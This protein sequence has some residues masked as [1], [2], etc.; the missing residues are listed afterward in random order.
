MKTIPKS[1]LDLL[2]Q[3]WQ[4]T[5]SGTGSAFESVFEEE[6]RRRNP[7]FY[8]ASEDE[9]S[10]IDLLRFEEV[11]GLLRDGVLNHVTAAVRHRP[12]GA[13]YTTTNEHAQ[14]AIYDFC[15]A[16]Y[17]AWKQL[18]RRLNAIEQASHVSANQNPDPAPNAQRAQVAQVGVITH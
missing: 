1:L 16:V 14:H 3:E 8:F 13:R 6:D 11:A 9:Q 5:S 10:D 18:Q 12:S 4:A 7:S 17:A 15:E 2:A